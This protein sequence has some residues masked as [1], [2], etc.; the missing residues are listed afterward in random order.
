M[1]ASDLAQQVTSSVPSVASVRGAVDLRRWS[2]VPAAPLATHGAGLLKF[3]R[4]PMK[5]EE[6]NPVTADIDRL[7]TLEVLRLIN[8]EDQT[9]AQAVAGALPE[10]ARAVEGIADRLRGGGRL[11]YVGT[12]TSG[13][14]A[15]LDA[16]ECP[17][18]FGTAPTLVQA[19]IAGGSEA[20][21]RAVEAAEDDSRQGARDLASIGLTAADALVGVSASGQT[22]YT[23]GAVKYA[24]QTG[25][26]TVAI[27]CNRDSPI[28]REAEVAIEVETGPEVI[29]GSTRMK[30]GTAQKLILNMIS[31]A[32]MIRLGHVYG[33][34][35]VNVQLKNRK[36]VA[37]G[38]G[39]VSEVAG[40]PEEV[41]RSA[42][43]KA[44][45]VKV[46]ILMLKRNLDREQARRL[47][48]SR[49]SLRAAL[50]EDTRA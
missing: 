12:G 40:V 23:S 11:Y 34:L 50:D 18:T 46:A 36:L 49:G 43:D 39:I 3:S 1:A 6:R 21:Y 45:S 26:F 20:T 27:S 35:M 42:L 13:R 25:S 24:R 17:P 48:D 37:R 29:S 10:I 15:V 16:A 28:S 4:I 19:V 22:P 5:T 14:L 9:V 32:T 47:L 44:G 31:T 38:E 33:N 7:E 30:A 41:A 2:A 8:V